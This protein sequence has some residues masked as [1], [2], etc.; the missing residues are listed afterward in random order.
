MPALMPSVSDESKRPVLM[1]SE[2]MI[3]LEVAPLAPQARL[4]ATSSG[5]TESSHSLVPQAMRDCNGVVMALLL[6]R[7]KSALVVDLL[8]ASVF[9]HYQQGIADGHSPPAFG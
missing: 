1:R 2:T 3:G 9:R 6:S 7:A 8:R 5:S 4:R